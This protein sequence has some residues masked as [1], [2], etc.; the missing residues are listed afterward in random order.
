[1]ALR[2]THILRFLSVACLALACGSCRKEQQPSDADLLFTADAPMLRAAAKAYVLPG[3]KYDYVCWQ[4][5]DCVVVNGVRCVLAAVSSG[6][7]YRA[8]FRADGVTKADGGY[9]A[10]FPESRC[11]GSAGGVRVT[12]PC[13]EA[14]VPSD[15]SAQQFSLPMAAWSEGDR[16]EFESLCAVL[17]LSA[18]ASESDSVSIL[19][20]RVEADKGLSGTFEAVRQSGWSMADGVQQ[21]DTARCLDFGG[22]GLPLAA[23]P[24][25]F[26]LAV[27]PVADV[28]R[29]S[30]AV[31]LSQKGVRHAYVRKWPAGSSRFAFERGCVYDMGLL[32]L[33]A[34]SVTVSDEWEE[35]S[36]EF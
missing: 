26:Y 34:G 11:A 19:E 13:S 16:L 10:V 22:A 30:V 12:L 9:W 15:V 1:M 28:S 36:I 31:V 27:P 17:H 23:R 8:T 14:Y 33:C 7:S 35:Q 25:D 5:G 21:A 20:W 29:V 2:T 3:V 18:A 4:P 32:S 6:S 24:R